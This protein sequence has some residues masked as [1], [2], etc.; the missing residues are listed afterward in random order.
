MESIKIVTSPNLF[1]IGAQKCGTTWLHEALCKSK[2][3]HGSKPKEVNYWN[4]TPM[5]AF[6]D[7]EKNFE[8]GTGFERYVFESTPHYFRLPGNSSDNAQRIS[9]VLGDVEM[10]LILRNPVDR[11]LSAYTHNMMKGYLPVVQ[12]V[13]EKTKHFGLIDLGC[14]GSILEHFSQHFSSIR[15]Y[16]YDDLMHDRL[17]FVRRIFSDL[18]VDF[19]L[20]EADLNFRANDKH[21]KAQ[22]LNIIT[23][24][25]LSS[26]LTADLK[27]F[28]KPEI[29]KVEEITGLDF[30]HW[31]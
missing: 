17:A 22:K 15:V 28:Y 25:K 9:S 20:L 3:F 12:M 5:A 19:D 29:E 24:P 14:Y 21:V 18:L 30:G 23:M 27:Q 11:F 7:Y 1:I 31:K 4:K 10:I 26:A 16:S 13:V 2:H 8:G 6:E